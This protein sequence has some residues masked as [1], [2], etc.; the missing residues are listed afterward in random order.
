MNSLR[1]F[2]VLIATFLTCIPS[3][4]SYLTSTSSMSRLTRFSRS[5]MCLRQPQLLKLSM[6][7]SDSLEQKRQ[8]AARLLNEARLAAEEAE[9]AA[10]RAAELKASFPPKS[11]VAEVRPPVSAE[12]VETFGVRPLKRDRSLEAQFDLSVPDRKL[13]VQGRDEDAAFG[14][15]GATMR[16]VKTLTWVGIGLLLLVEGWALTQPTSPLMNPPSAPMEA[17][18]ARRPPL[19][20][21]AVED[22]P[23]AASA[24]TRLPP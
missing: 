17:R 18:S 5:E 4:Q 2:A 6:S 23:A 1:G 10:K 11:P 20:P 13:D 9:A 21:T 15:S 3:A 7:D 12:D 16:N 22:P 8:E 24:E 14:L 19:P